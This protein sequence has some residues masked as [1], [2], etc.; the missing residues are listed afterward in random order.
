MV[1]QADPAKSGLFW[2]SFMGGVDCAET[3]A[4]QYA[5]LQYE[6]LSGQ[7]QSQGSG[8]WRGNSR[9]RHHQQS[10]GPKPQFTMVPPPGVVSSRL[11]L[12]FELLNSS[13]YKPNLV[14]YMP[15]SLIMVTL[16]TT[17]QLYYF[18]VLSQL[19]ITSHFLCLYFLPPVTFSSISSTYRGYNIGVIL[20]SQQINSINSACRENKL[21]VADLRSPNPM[22]PAARSPL[23]NITLYLA[24][25]MRRIHNAHFYSRSYYNFD[26]SK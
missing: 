13:A 10:P 4:H 14:K 5:L 3:E 16:H 7:Q 24:F 23:A 15:S 19:L 25:E 22:P 8:R 6:D 26:L 21:C 1:L 2:M 9:A 17:F 20:S 12:H 11:T 18:P